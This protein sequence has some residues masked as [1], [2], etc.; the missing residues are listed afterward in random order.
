MATRKTNA[1][2]SAADTSARLKTPATGQAGAADAAAPGN[3]EGAEDLPEAEAGRD[4]APMQAAGTSAAAPAGEAALPASPA[5]DLTEGTD[6]DPHLA[7]AADPLTAAVAAL[8]DTTAEMLPPGTTIHLQR[9]VAYVVSPIVHDG[10]LFGA[11]EPI[12]LTEVEFHRLR[13]TGALAE[14]DWDDLAEI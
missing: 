2:V 10:Y 13:P 4:E 1:E 6:D 12:P 11:D 8:K 7:P 5:A 9:R 14:A 3:T